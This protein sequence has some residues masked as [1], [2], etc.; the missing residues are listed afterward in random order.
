MWPVYWFCPVCLGACLPVKLA[1]AGSCGS[2]VPTTRFT[3]E[4]TAQN[5]E[6]LK[7][8]YPE[9]SS[10]VQDNIV[11]KSVEV[12]PQYS[13][14]MSQMFIQSS[15][16]VVNKGMFTRVLEGV[17]VVAWMAGVVETFTDTH[18]NS[19]DK[20]AA[21]SG[22]I[23]VVGEIL[24]G[25]DIA[26][27]EIESMQHTADELQQAWTAKIHFDHN[28]LDDLNTK[29]DQE[30]LEQ[31]GRQLDILFVKSYIMWVQQYTV[32]LQML[33]HINHLLDRHYII[34]LYRSIY[35]DQ[36]PQQLEQQRLLQLKHCAEHAPQAFSENGLLNPNVV[37]QC[38][39]VGLKEW[40]K[41]IAALYLHQ[42]PALKQKLIHLGQ[43]LYTAKQ[44][45]AHHWKS[46]LHDA[47]LKAKKQFSRLAD[48]AAHTLFQSKSWDTYRHHVLEKGFN[49][50][51]DIWSIRN[52]ITM[53]GTGLILTVKKIKKAPFLG[54]QMFLICTRLNTTANFMG[55]S[56]PTCR[57]P[58]RN[59]FY[60]RLNSTDMPEDFLALQQ[61]VN[62]EESFM[63]HAQAMQNK[64]FKFGILSYRFN[65][66][67]GVQALRKDVLTH[68]LPS[69]LNTITYKQ[70]DIVNFNPNFLG[71]T[72]Q[73]I[74]DE[75]SQSISTKKKAQMS[76]F[77]D[78]TKTYQE[79]PVLS[80]LFKGIVE[81]HNLPWWPQ[82]ISSLVYMDLNSRLALD[83]CMEEPCPSAYGARSFV[84]DE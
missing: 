67:Q 18:S 49:Y 54:Y 57:K 41:P 43:Q 75:F 59:N 37:M 20:I 7:D 47:S 30:L 56:Y 31:Y 5:I 74:D 82:F 29:Y 68:N 10:Y 15:S 65:Q 17:S 62:S 14:N 55:I 61:K 9:I 51:F 35:A 48:S 11:Q 40:M 64:W 32:S 70:D 77:M 80:K 63:K 13:E 22:I 72:L 73:A 38:Y 36:T 71:Q 8:F 26:Y 4:D 53:F 83:Y 60:L 46:S 81:F 2:D 34:E 16:Q 52:Q 1:I 21:V 23:P 44:K 79:L 50:A 69:H 45:I 12:A 24:L 76:Y 6:D 42:N 66:S 3:A 28:S 19:L 27:D 39:Q 33:K 25:F 84:Q 58:Y 78:E